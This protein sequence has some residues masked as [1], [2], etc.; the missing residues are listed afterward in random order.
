MSPKKNKSRK[1][2]KPRTTGIPTKTGRQHSN[3]T[4]WIAIAGS[5]IIIA[6]VLITWYQLRTPPESK[7]NVILVII[8]TVRGDALGCYGN[9]LN[10]SPNIDAVAAD[11]IRFD[12]AISSSGWTLP[13]VASLLTGTWPTI[14]GGMGKITKL[15]T[16]RDELPTAAEIMKDA[17][18][19]TF[20]FA[21]AAFVS[22]MLNLD[23]GFDLF[24][25]KYTYNDNYRRANETIAAVIP[26]LK[27]NRSNANFIMIHLFDPH[28]DYGAPPPYRFKYTDGRDTPVAPLDLDACLD[29]QQDDGDS[30]PSQ[31]DIRYVKNVYMGEINFVDSQIGVLMDQL[32]ALDM[33]DDSMIIITSDHGEEFWEHGKFE[34][35]HTLYDELVHVPLII[36]YPIDIIPALKTIDTQIRLID[37]MPTVFD[38]LNIEKPELFI[39]ESLTPLVMGGEGGHRGAYCEGTLYGK[40]KIAWR[41]PRYKYILELFRNVEPVEELYDWQNDPGE[42]NDLSGTLPEQA[43]KMRG[44][45]IRFFMD[46]TKRADGMSQPSQVDLSPDRIEMLKSLG[47][48][49]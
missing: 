16:I 43:E 34:H 27:K 30:P 49:R 6:A 38:W 21:N 1:Q 46:I 36:K 29:L 26:I 33:Y 8:D 31:Q 40:N 12:Q 2:Q 11:G 7:K 39:G 9:P 41:G 17:G 3:R 20:A 48:I 45:L 37:I 42:S 24:D 25:H 22:P 35:G 5:V 32:H 15:T 10:P 19:R 23:R 13:S 18:Y 14:H 28:L 44:E 47:Y 4:K